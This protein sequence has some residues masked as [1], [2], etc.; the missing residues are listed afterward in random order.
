MA[1]SL[2]RL[3]NKLKIHHL[4]VKLFHMVKILRKSILYIRRYST[5]YASF[6]AVLY[7]MF[8][9]KPCHLWSY[10]AKVHQFFRRYSA[11]ISAVNVHS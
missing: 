10:Q 6:L 7:L 4:H 8:T 11:F 3:E 5:K 9:N 2:D 1:T